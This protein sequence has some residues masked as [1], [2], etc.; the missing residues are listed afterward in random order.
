MFPFKPSI[1]LLLGL[2]SASMTPAQ[3]IR[4]NPAMQQRS[5]EVRE[6]RG[7]EQPQPREVVVI[8]D[9]QKP[10][11]PAPA[12]G[13]AI[14]QTQP[15]PAQ[16]VP[17]I[18]Q[19]RQQGHSDAPAKPPGFWHWPFGQKKTQ[20]AVPPLDGDSHEIAARALK[21]VGLKAKFG[22][23]TNG[24]VF[25]QDPPAGQMVD[26]GSQVSVSLG[27][28]RVVVPPLNGMT[29]AKARSALDESGLVPG[30]VGGNNTEGSTVA[31]QSLTAG[32]RVPRGTPVGLTMQPPLP[33][34]PQPRV[35]VSTPTPPPPIVEPPSVVPTGIRR[36][37]PSPTPW[38]QTAP[39]VL[40]LAG[41][42]LAGIVSLGLL[43]RKP[44]TPPGPPAGFSLKVNRGAARTRFREQDDPKIRFTVSL[45][46]RMAAPRYKMDKGPAVWRKG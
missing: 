31:S 23:G 33:A 34:E 17:N 8:P 11:P 21:D 40:S 6:V 45:R 16:V 18:A 29:E 1:M 14:S 38:W 41:I 30:D 36:K 15:G 12:A 7:K 39:G 4:N 5:S 37:R 19:T 43:F 44:I 13:P 28:P 20:V 26:S 2:Y 22:G 9:R 27:P 42:A 46:D 32:V 3:E 25:Q 10:R 35:V 24:V